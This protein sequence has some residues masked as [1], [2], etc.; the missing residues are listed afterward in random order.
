MPQCGDGGCRR[1]TAPPCG[2]DAPPPSSTRRSRSR[3]RR[4]RC[5]G[6]S[7]VVHGLE[8]GAQYSVWLQGAAETAVG[9][10]LLEGVEARHLHLR[11]LAVAAAAVA[12]GAPGAAPPPAE[13]PPAPIELAV[14]ERTC[15][16]FNISWRMPPNTGGRGTPCAAC[17]GRHR[18]RPDGPDGGGRALVAPDVVVAN[19]ACTRA[20]AASASPASARARCTPSPSPPAPTSARARRRAR[21]PSR[22]AALRRARRRPPPAARRAPSERFDL[23]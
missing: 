3:S 19:P 22:C 6:C 5:G 10:E 8:P 23:R 12:A 11:L 16:A 13:P 18:V 21:S 7:A 9:K 1:T 14:V 2:N 4:H 17:V 15:S 20:P